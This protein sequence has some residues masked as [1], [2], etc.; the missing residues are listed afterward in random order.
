MLGERAG[1]CVASAGDFDGDGADDLLVGAVMFD[2]TYLV[3]G[4]PTGSF[5]TADA[6]A[7]FLAETGGDRAG[8]VLGTA[9]DWNADGY[10]DLL[11]A[12]PQHSGVAPGA[13]A[14]YVF[15]GEGL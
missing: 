11:I 9:G 10:A 5:S 7:T 13:G 3:Y 2:R 4:P 12:A 6:D 8:Q 14:V 1:E 15:L